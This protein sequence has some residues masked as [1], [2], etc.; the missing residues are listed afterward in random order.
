MALHHVT[1]FFG[2]P[3]VRSS[4]GRDSHIRGD[5]QRFMSNLDN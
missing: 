4:T 5:I 3:F 2:I 1:P